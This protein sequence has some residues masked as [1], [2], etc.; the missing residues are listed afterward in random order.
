MKTVPSGNFLQEFTPIADEVG[1]ERERFIIQRANGRHLVLMSLDDYNEMQ[2][3][4]YAGR[5]KPSK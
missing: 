4:I 5:Q 1:A 2:R 3:E